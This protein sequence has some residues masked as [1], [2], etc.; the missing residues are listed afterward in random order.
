MDSS[1]PPPLCKPT[2]RC[3]PSP[4]LSLIAAQ[5]SF[6]GIRLENAVTVQ[7]LEINE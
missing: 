3:K 4:S 5:Q 6:Q 2:A 1:H 7:L